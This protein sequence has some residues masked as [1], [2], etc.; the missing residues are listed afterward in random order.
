MYFILYTS[1]NFGHLSD[2]LFQ[3]SVYF[4]IIKPEFR[5]QTKA[6][7]QDCPVL[8]LARKRR[9]WIYLEQTD[10][11]CWRK[12]FS[13]STSRHYM[14]S[15]LFPPVCS[16]PRG[17]QTQQ[18]TASWTTHTCRTEPLPSAASLRYRF[19][20]SFPSHGWD[21]AFLPPLCMHI[22]LQ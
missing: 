6:T 14:G 1:V 17:C 22:F 11:R 20:S 4:H 15:Q 8:L 10:G 16:K 2:Q 13:M 18:Q 3:R 9:W 19:N 12:A 21:A 5:K 7:W